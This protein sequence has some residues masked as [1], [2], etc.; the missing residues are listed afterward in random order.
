MISSI[1]SSNKQ[2][3]RSPEGNN[4][5]LATK[6]GQIFLGTRRIR[7][8]CKQVIICDNVIN[9]DIKLP[10]GN[11]IG[12]RNLDKVVLDKGEGV[13]PSDHV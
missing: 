1:S 3:A 13:Q 8:G 9:D 12:L 11:A 7:K 10:E 4:V 6:L 2:N 5:R